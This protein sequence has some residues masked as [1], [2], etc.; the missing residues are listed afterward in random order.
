MMIF[1]AILVIATLIAMASGRVP[2]VLAL[3]VPLPSR[4][5]RV[6]HRSTNSSRV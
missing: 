5:S 2:P 6:L 4:P 3:D 1:A